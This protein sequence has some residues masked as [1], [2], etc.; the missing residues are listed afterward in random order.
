MNNIEKF[1]RKIE[2]PEEECEVLGAAYL[3]I[4]ENKSAY[5]VFEECVSVY[6]QNTVFDRRPIFEKIEGL[7]EIIDIHKYT[8]DLMY[9]IM[10]V[11]HMKEVYEE[12]GLTE[13]VFNDSVLDLKW[14]SEECKSVYGVWGISVAGWTLDFFMLKR[15]AFGRLQFNL[16]SFKLDYSISGVNV[17]SGDQYI[18]T[19]IPSGRP[20]VHEECRLSYDR[21]A[22]HF[23]NI[24]GDKPIIFGCNSWLLSPNNRKIL[25]ETSN[26]LKFMDDYEILEPAKDEKNSNLWRIFSV[27]ELP[28]NLDDLPQNT[29]VQRAF[30]KWLKE[31]NTIDR[32]F[33]AFIY[34]HRFRK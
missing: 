7:S 4:V 27:E 24:F 34:P 20:L 21:A 33:G 15:L 32:A 10:L 14:K 2:M 30:A 22:E 11:P 13:E 17:K 5:G 1:C 19:H 31:G 23:K 16:G 28:A 26:I 25:P 9:L 12:N 18:E 3:K 29:S 6:K 8:L